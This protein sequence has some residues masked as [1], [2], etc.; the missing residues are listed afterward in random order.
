MKIFLR[1]MIAIVRLSFIE[2]LRRN[3]LYALLALAF[4]LMIPLSMASPFG[5]GGAGRYLDE[6]ALLL[7]W[8]FSLFIAVGA[9]SRLLPPEFANRTIYPL[10]A[11]PISRGRLLLGKYLGA[12][13]SSSAAVL[14]F[15]FL[16]AGSVLLRDGTLSMAMVEAVVL[17]IL[18]VALAVAVSLLGS[19]IFTPSANLV[20]S[21]GM[22]TTMFFFGRRL[23]EYADTAGG[24]L[25][26]LVL[27]LYAVAPHAEFFDLRQ[28]VVH[29]WGAVDAGV[30]L[31]V[32][33]Y[34][35][36]YCGGLL[37]LSRL[38]LGKKKL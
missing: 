21:A 37:A 4:T 14:L 27:A 26:A 20:L 3:D 2:L 33:A 12:M 25:K 19:L 8:G 16:F 18:F 31:A 38:A 17:H 1:Q 15:Y 22:L 7:V 10:L 13:L 34:A 24:A 9:G 6:V 28:R 23:P 35:A 5:A 32:L 36:C 11:K 30:V 29:G